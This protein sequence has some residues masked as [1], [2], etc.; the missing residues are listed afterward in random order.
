MTTDLR[1]SILV[2]RQV[3]EFVRDEY[4]L[5][6]TFLEAYYEFLEQKQGTKINDLI[7]QAKNL[8]HVSDVDD[9]I[10][11][12]EKNFINNY[13][14]LFPLDNVADKALLIKKALPLYL[15]KGSVKSFELLFRLLYGEEVT[16]TYPKDN[17][18]R[19]SDGKWVVENVVRIDND[20]YSYYEG[21]GTTKIFILPQEVADS[22]VTVYVNDVVT[23]TGFYIL[24][25][26]KKIVF[27]SAP[28]SNAKIKVV[29]DDFDETLF[30][31]RK[32]TGLTSGATAIVERAAPRLITQQTSIELYVDE[33]TL[34]GSFLN[35]ETITSDVFADDGVTLITIR[36]D[37]VATLSSITII[38]GGTSYNVGDPVTII[39]GAPQIPA[40]AIVDQVSVGFADAANVGY[41]GAGFALGGIITA[42]NDDGTI[43]LASQAIDT[44][45][46]NSANS[47]T[48]FTDTINTYAN[49]VLSNPNY[50]FPSTVI[51]TGEN[52]ATRLVDAFSKATI[53]DIGPMTNVTI[54]YSG[55]DTSNLT[56]DADGAKYANTFDIKSFG[57]IGR[58]DIISGG[59][60]YR[61]GDEIVMG[62]N[63]AGT[64]GRGF[65]A[66][67]TNT[68]ASGAITRVEIQPTR[69]TGNA[70]TTAGN[71]VVVGTGTD[72]VNEL[73]IGDRIMIN[74]EAR[75]V[76]SILSSTSL[77]VNVSFT[78]TSTERRIG[79]FDRYLIGGQGYEQNNFPTV[80]VSSATGSAANLQI[81]SLM[82]DGERLGI[83]GSGI[84]GQIT[85]IKI[86]NPG[87]GYQFIPTI[88]LGNFGDG[89]AT[90][91]AQ[92]ERSFIS[93]PGKWVGSDGIL[94]SLD[95]KIEG[96]DYYIDFTYVTSVATEFS[97]YAAI[98]KNLLHPAGFRNF[99]E[100]PI[101]RSI[102]SEATVD[103]SVG[104]TIS[105]LVSTTNGSIIV[106]G[107]NTKFNIA[108]TLGI[109]SI[110]T[111]IAINNQI[112]TIN[113]IVSNTSLTVSSAFTSN[114][115]AQTLIIIT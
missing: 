5:F 19:A 110:G 61:I 27:N 115:S 70:N 6:V 1:T 85:R 43:T 58:I 41:G 24:K 29:Y 46:A 113:A 42:F 32:I 107:T 56:I 57:S 95:R 20:V 45:G 81:T 87:A 75:Y 114:A 4:P 55:T 8:R 26:A 83:T 69:I 79:A 99:A 90:A 23:T 68:N 38:N 11:Q 66:A 31:N 64:Y 22:D 36:S 102:D 25:E 47:Y 39:G 51:P 34:L 63:P 67:V 82:G 86:T 100:Y 84:S 71:V 97:K 21:D 53:T 44:S 52:I 7:T 2:N 96:L 78:R 14:P 73:M 91:N 89:T 62:A 28:A 18:L 101:S 33:S 80:S 40:E 65:A 54:L 17:I 104:E 88:D 103:S 9:S 93:F 106:T 76:N 15:T 60:G 98:L 13:A 30:T 94:S 59:T 12:F 16:I 48:I 10:E 112:R 35:A 109:I 74:S 105:G 111:Q 77:N 49:I 50:G 37:T 72:F 3:P 92:I 108:N